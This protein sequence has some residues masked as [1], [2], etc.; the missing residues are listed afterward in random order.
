MAEQSGEAGG[1]VA[2][3]GGEDAGAVLVF[4]G[5]GGGAGGEDGVEVGGEED[6][7]AGGSEFEARVR[8]SRAEFGEGVA[9][10]VEVD[11]GEAELVEAVEEPGGA[12]VLRRR[13]GRGCGRSR[14]A[15]GGVGAGGDA[16]SGRRDG[17]R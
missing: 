14:V 3:A 6:D 11:V 17:R 2:D 7:R 15:T 5:F 16:A 9:C 10:V 12:G 1:V 13:V 8:D 4:G